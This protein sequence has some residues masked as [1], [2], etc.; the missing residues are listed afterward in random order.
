MAPRRLLWYCSLAL[1]AAS[2]AFFLY[3]LQVTRSSE[4]ESVPRFEGPL[5][6]SAESLE[7]VAQAVSQG[8]AGRSS[9]FALAES[10]LNLQTGA[11]YVAIR[12]A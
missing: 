5:W 4:S 12:S 3:A 1:F 8:L 2:L 11:V 10:E 9:A 7:Q 6:L